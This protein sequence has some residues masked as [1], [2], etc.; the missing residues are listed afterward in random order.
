ML[1]DSRHQC[2]DELTTDYSELPHLC[3]AEGGPSTPAFRAVSGGSLG[4]VGVFLAGGG[5]G[6]AWLLPLHYVPSRD[7][8]ESLVTELN[9]LIT[10]RIIRPELLSGEVIRSLTNK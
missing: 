3:N 6:E 1:C 8:A 2:R 5:Q 4:G 10:N 9:T 7:D